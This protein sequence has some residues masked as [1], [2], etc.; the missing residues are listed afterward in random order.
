MISYSA[1]LWHQPLFAFARLNVNDSNKLSL[2][3]A[4]LTACT[5]VFAYLSW[6]FIEEPFRKKYFLKENR[7]IFLVAIAVG[8][9]LIVIGLYGYKSKGWLS[10]YSGDKKVILEFQF[11]DYEHVLRRHT[12][13]MEPKNSFLDFKKECFGVGTS[14][15]NLIWGDSYA[16]ASSY[17]LRRSRGDVIQLTASACPPLI[18]IRFIDRPNCI[19]VNNFV[20][21]KITKLKPAIIY[22]QANWYSYENSV[23]RL[24]KTL[25]FIKKTSPNSRVIIVGSTPLWEPSLPVFLFRKNVHL[26]DDTYLEMPRYKELRSID[27]SLRSLAVANKVQFLSVLDHMCIANKC[28]V[29][30]RYNGYY[31]L[32]A[33]DG[34]H[35]TEAGSVFL[36]KKIIN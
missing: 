26:Q 7:S 11:Y 35:L 20:K 36:W 16:A 18:N 31:S 21:E 23:A 12:C 9:A 27:E 34:G 15:S 17:G 10:R 14:D 1:Y 30:Y 22:L 33:Y 13:F 5:F 29:A 25:E 24:S 3:L 32:T 2:I 8:L 6:R 19:Q 28:L 4:F